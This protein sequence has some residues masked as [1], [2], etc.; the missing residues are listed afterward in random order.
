MKKRMAALLASLMA[1]QLVACGGAAGNA[2][3]SAKETTAETTTAA[4]VKDTEAASTNADS[5]GDGEVTIRLS[6]WGGDS[7]HE[8]T[9]EAVD[10]FMEA[11]PNIKVECEYGAWNGWTEKISTSLVAGASADVMQ[12]NWNW[13]YQFSSDGSKY[14][15]L[16]DYADVFNDFA[17]YDKTTLDTCV[18]AGKQQAIPISTTGKVFYWNKT[19]FDKAGI[20]IPTT[21]DELIAAGE[22][23]KEKL[24]DDYYPLA[25]FEYERYLLMVYYLESKYEKPWAVDNQCNYTVEEITDG[26]EWINSLE[27]HHV[28]P[29]IEY[30]KGQGVDT[31]EK[32]PDWAC[33]KYAGFFERS[34]ERRSEERR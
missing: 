5:T 7:R 23:F 28:L 9:L 32:N 8:K 17:D 6:W 33:G 24:G 12:T 18:V 22:T 16:N 15:D 19:T 31:I 11:Y 30:L 4:E 10:K 21:F 26:L 29:S 2:T 3:Q 1:L 34:E 27:E 25:L 14:A 20:A 13:L